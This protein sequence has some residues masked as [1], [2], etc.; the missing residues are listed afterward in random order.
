M[1]L[2]QLLCTEQYVSVTSKNLS[3]LIDSYTQTIE[4]FS[5]LCECLWPTLV[6]S[7]WM[8]DETPIPLKHV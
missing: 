4:Q 6:L 2:Y 5:F 7:S 3:L 8:F 1:A